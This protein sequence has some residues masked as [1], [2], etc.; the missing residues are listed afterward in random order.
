M[1]LLVFLTKRIYHMT[2]ANEFYDLF[3]VSSKP[4]FF[5][6][7]LTA[8]SLKLYTSRF[9]NVVNK[10]VILSTMILLAS[11]ASNPPEQ[12]PIEKKPSTISSGETKLSV[13]KFSRDVTY[14]PKN[15]SKKRV[16]YKETTEIGMSYSLIGA[17]GEKGKN[18]LEKNTLQ[19]IG[20]KN[21]RCVLYL[22]DG[23]RLQVKTSKNIEPCKPTLVS[24]TYDVDNIT[25][26][27][28]SDYAF[29]ALINM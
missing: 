1:K 23:Y 10:F 19:Y 26:G 24:K 3:R 8:H 15:K 20:K 16:K 29:Q 11:C 18:E 17:I 14:I 7:N 2:L 5:V 21:I 4:D 6:L 28:I 22:Y 12:V 13:K 25:S 27:S 9:R